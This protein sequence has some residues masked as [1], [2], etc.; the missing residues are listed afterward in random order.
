MNHI[1]KVAF[2]QNKVFQNNDE[3]FEKLV[4]GI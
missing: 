4:N 2:D 1:F 3:I